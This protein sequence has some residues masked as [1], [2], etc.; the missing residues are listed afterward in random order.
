MPDQEALAAMYGVEYAAVAEVDDPKD[1]ELLLDLL[2][3]RGT[4][5]LIEF[6]CGRGDLLGSAMRLGWKAFGIELDS[7]V[8]REAKS[9]TGAEVVSD[10][11]QLLEAGI[12]ADV[13]YFQDVLEHLV[14]VDSVLHTALQLLRPGGYLAAQGPLEANAN[15]FTYALRVARTVRP[16]RSDMP[17]YHVMLATSDGQRALFHRFGLE[18]VEYRVNEVSWPAPARIGW[19]DAR[20]PRTM[21]LF[22]L[23]RVS[24]ALTTLR[25]GDWGNRFFFVGQ[26]KTA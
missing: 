13:V 22:A 18:E 14:D 3:R 9:R 20:N 16:R 1:P 6:G 8:V 25:G 12:R 11:G 19:Q 17:P 5:T 23:R 10:P 7:E 4:G 2:R 24:R 21:G 15:L 26:K